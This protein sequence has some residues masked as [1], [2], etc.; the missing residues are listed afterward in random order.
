MSSAPIIGITKPDN[1]DFLAYCALWLSVK[2]AGG[3]PIVLSASHEGYEGVTIDGLLL[4]GGKDVFPGRY[5]QPPKEDYIYDPDRDEM[6]VFWAERAK[7]ENIPTLGICRGA[8][9]INVVCGGAVHMSVS[10]A[11]EDA[12]YPDGILH[13]IFY[14]KK[15]M[16]HEN[17]PLYDI[18][19]R[20]ELDVNSIHKQAIAVLGEGLE[21]NARENNGVIQA[22]SLKD[23]PMYLGVQFH[24]EF[25][26]HR[27]IF[28]SLFRALVVKAGEKS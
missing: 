5:N 8:Q 15:I 4:G 26:I 24:P 13:N 16:I 20:T 27:K 14:R 19:K 25:L 22:V 1:K 17:C 18:L 7:E 11:Y 6:E 12:H 3:R 2:I 28:R 21:I 10:D 9:L 23:H